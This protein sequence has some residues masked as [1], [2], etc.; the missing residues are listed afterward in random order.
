MDA[1]GCGNLGLG[2]EDACGCL[3]VE[4]SLIV[5]AVPGGSNVLPFWVAYCNPP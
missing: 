5:A 1:V 4:V 2:R 3:V